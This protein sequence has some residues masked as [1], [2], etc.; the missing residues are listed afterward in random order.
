MTVTKVLA[1]NYYT[2]EG[3]ISEILA[4]I[5]SLPKGSVIGFTYNLDDNCYAVLVAKS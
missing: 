1:G 4:E 3:S 2:L 5:G